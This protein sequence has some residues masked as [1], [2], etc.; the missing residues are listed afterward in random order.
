M[1]TPKQEI[2]PPMRAFMQELRN[3]IVIGV[4][5]GSDLVKQKEQ[6]GQNVTEEFDYSFS[7]NGLIGYKSG[8]RIHQQVGLVDQF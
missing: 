5:G 2:E 6:V 1:S 8:V 4:V 7:E 3:K